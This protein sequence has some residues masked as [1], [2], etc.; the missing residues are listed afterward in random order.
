[1]WK[2]YIAWII[3]AQESMSTWVENGA[4]LKQDFAKAYDMLD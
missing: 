3:V 2:I 1:M 4:L